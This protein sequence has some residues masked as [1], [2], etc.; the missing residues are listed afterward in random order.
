MTLEPVIAVKFP[1]PRYGYWDGGEKSGG[2]FHADYF[3]TT[4][5]G[6]DITM[7][8]GCWELNFWFNCGSGRSWKEATAIAVRK[9]K[10]LCTVEGTEISVLWK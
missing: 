3:T 4:H 8:W 1:K 6:K 7:R 5:P 2:E 10:H 9:L